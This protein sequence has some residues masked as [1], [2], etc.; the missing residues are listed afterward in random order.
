M[1][2]SSLWCRMAFHLGMIGGA[3]LFIAGCSLDNPTALKRGGGS[4]D[5]ESSWQALGISYCQSIG[6]SEFCDDFEDGNSSSNPPWTIREQS[7]A[8][9]FSVFSDNGNMVYRQGNTSTS[10]TRRISSAGP[11]W[12]NA[13][14]EGKLKVLSFNGNTNNWAGIYARYNTGAQTG[15]IFSIRGDGKVYLRKKTGSGNSG[16]C[17]PASWPN[18]SC[19]QT[20]TPPVTANTWY[21]LKLVLNGNTLTGYV[22]GTKVIEVVDN[23]Q[24]FLSPGGIAVGSTGGATFAVDNI[25]VNRVPGLCANP[26]GTYKPAGTQCRASIGECDPIETCT[27]S[28]AECPADHFA[29]NTQVCRAKVSLCDVEEFCTGDSVHCPVDGFLQ[30]TQI[31]NPSIG[32]CDPAELCTGNAPTC[33]QNMTQGAP[34]VP[35]GL[36][37]IPGNTRTTLTWVPSAQTIEYKVK[38][39]SSS[40]GAYVQVATVL[41]PPV[42]DEGLDNETTYFYRVSAL[43]PCGESEN[44]GEVSA[45]PANISDQVLNISIPFPKGVN[46]DSVAI[47]A[48]GSLR[49]NDRV[50][51]YRID[52]T[53]AAVANAGVGE[54][55]LGVD[56]IA[57]SVTSLAPVT[58]RDRSQVLGDITTSSV[59]LR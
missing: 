7:I 29:P 13:T 35:T 16:D 6:A 44:S 53:A 19:G 30:A 39:A 51:V 46:R 58:L 47:A 25:T 28:S 1:L 20:I 12:L 24:P 32:S 56:S 9:D 41:N 33:P 10:S 17:M 5:I 59:V 36:I 2:V 22:N 50:K 37:A 42:V 15:Y 57:G 43:G 38:R 40:K 31:C 3:S 18:T 14:I 4:G 11:N 54:T 27:G 45:T 23:N 55:N 26:D 49:L 48:N 8:S 52:G 34:T 21:A